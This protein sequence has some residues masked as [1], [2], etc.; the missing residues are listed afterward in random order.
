LSG[1]FEP[2]ANTQ[3]QAQSHRA[4]EKLR[5]SVRSGMGLHCQ[6]LF[7]PLAPLGLTLPPHSPVLASQRRE[8]SVVVFLDGFRQSTQQRGDERS[9]K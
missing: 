3:R 8:E 5:P 4:L 9:F 7:L 1:A 6:D 2:L